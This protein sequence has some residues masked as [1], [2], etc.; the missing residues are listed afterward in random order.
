MVGDKSFEA[1]MEKGVPM[2]TVQVNHFE[3]KF[4]KIPLSSYFLEQFKFFFYNLKVV[5]KL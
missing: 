4:P 5:E 2:P 3:R 1:F